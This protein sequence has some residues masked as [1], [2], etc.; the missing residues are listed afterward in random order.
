MAA[1]PRKPGSPRLTGDESDDHLTEKAQAVITNH[2]FF[3]SLNSL[4]LVRT[5]KRKR[6]RADIYFRQDGLCRLCNEPLIGSWHI[7]HIIPYSW[8]PATELSNLQ[9]LCPRCNLRKGNKVTEQN[10]NFYYENANFARVCNLSKTRV[11]Q[12]GAINCALERFLNGATTNSCILPPRYGKSDI[13]RLTV[14]ELIHQ[15]AICGAIIVS[16][17][18]YL[19]D[20]IVDPHKI[21]EMMRRYEVHGKLRSHLGFASLRSFRPNLFDNGE[22]FES[23]TTQMLE[24]NINPMCKS[25]QLM[26]KRTGL[27]VLVS[28]DELHLMSLL[29]SWGQVVPRLLDAGALVNLTTATPWRSDNTKIPGLDYGDPFFEHTRKRIVRLIDET[30]EEHDLIQTWTDHV[31]KMG[32]KANYEYAY[33]RAWA[34]GGVI[35]WFDRHE[36]DVVITLPNGETKEIRD[37]SYNEARSN[38]GL[39]C[40][41]KIVV[42]ECSRKLVQQLSD[43]RLANRK[44]GGVVFCGNDKPN[45]EPNAHAQQIKNSILS[46]NSSLQ[47]LTATMKSDDDAN[48]VI[49]R[50][51]NGHGDILIVKLMACVGVDMPHVKVACDLSCVRSKASYI[52]RLFRPGTIW[53]EFNT[54]RWITPNDIIS[55]NIYEELIKN[56]GG[57]ANIISSILESEKEVEKS[58]ITREDEK[59]KATVESA[60]AGNICDLHGTKVSADTHEKLCRPL[61]QYMPGL[62]AKLTTPEIAQIALVID[63]KKLA[64][65]EKGQHPATDQ[66]INVDAVVSALHS[67]IN[68]AV[69][70]IANTQYDYGSQGKEWVDCCTRI[71]TLAKMHVG[72]HQAKQLKNI[73]NIEQLQK[74]KEFIEGELAKV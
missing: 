53:G 35:C 56:A 64:E 40:R 6:E 44:I 20:Q 2:G 65:A 74:M 46:H 28:I 14:I 30:N 62:Q 9:G 13:Q 60:R 18:A 19:R 57:E 69:K 63:A 3:L 55:Y 51:N 1:R 37:L 24:Q 34:E 68:G 32:L 71:H 70:D 16:P 11:G 61:I 31:S 66:V 4:S 5:L 15:K 17:S 7:D 29:N 59:N 52:Q 58:E 22:Y 73:R 50:F 38:M 33:S 41:D 54:A 43:L 27:P 45:D 36:V 25:L 72:I 42:D 48:N 8:V 49:R 67:Q 26:R 23:M 12:R 21:E 10:K 47:V 39:I